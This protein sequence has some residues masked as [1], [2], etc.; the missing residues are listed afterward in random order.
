MFPATLESVTPGFAG[1][2]I[3]FIVRSGRMLVYP[4]YEGSVNRFGRSISGADTMGM[5]RLVTAWRT[6]LGRTLDYLQ[7]RPDVDIERVG[8]LGVSLGASTALPAMTVEPRF[9]AAVLISGGVIA[10]AN[11]SPLTDPVNFAPRIRIPVLMFN[12]RYDPY[13]T[14]EENQLPLYRLLGSPSADKRYVQAAFAH[15]SPPR[16]ELLRETLAWYDKYLGPVGP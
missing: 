12:G 9:K 4:V 6:D 11:T 8:Y 7:T 10:S 3:E 5:N 16:P 2:P 13:F 15:A 14:V 1:M